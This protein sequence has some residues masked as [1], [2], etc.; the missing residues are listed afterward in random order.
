[1]E[2]LKKAAKICALN[3]LGGIVGC[4]ITFW[5][6]FAISARKD[7]EKWYTSYIELLRKVHESDERTIEKLKA[8]NEAID[9]ISRNG[10]A[11]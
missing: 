10:G 9:E 4:W 3:L 2:Q 6:L 8:L 7:A 11:K 5:P 1:M